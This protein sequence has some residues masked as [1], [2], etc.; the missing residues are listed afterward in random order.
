MVQERA[1]AFRRGPQLREEL[2]EQRHVEALIL[3]IFS[4]LSGSLP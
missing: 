2:R 1:V 3:A 4:I